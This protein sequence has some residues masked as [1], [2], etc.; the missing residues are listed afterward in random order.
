[1]SAKPNGTHDDPA[2]SPSR[3]RPGVGTVESARGY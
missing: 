3:P 2:T 1:M